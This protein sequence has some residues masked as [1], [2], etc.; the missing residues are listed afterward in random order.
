[1]KKFYFISLLSILG[2]W[3]T[4]ANA[5]SPNWSWAKAIGSGANLIND[6]GYSIAADASANIYTVGEFGGTVDF[7]PGIGVYN[8]TAAGPES[9]FISKLDSAGNFVWAKAMGGTNIDFSQ[10]IVL[11]ASGNVYTTGTFRWTVD[12]NPGAGTYNLSNNGQENTFISKLN[13]DGHFVWAKQM[14][15]TY[16]NDAGKSIAV[17]ELENVYTTGNFTDSADFDPGVGVYNLK[18]IDGPVIGRLQ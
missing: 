3:S 12:F 1:M 10:S 9:I 11:D 6:N 8:L 5:Q 7:D 2:G 17:D 4:I 14:G 16:P 13:T 15:G 18:A